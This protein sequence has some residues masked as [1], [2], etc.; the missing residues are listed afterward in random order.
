MIEIL[1]RRNSAVSYYDPLIPYLKIGHISLR[2]I[3]LSPKS[4]KKFD[5]VVI[6]TDHSKVDYKFI[7]KNSRLILDTRNVYKDINDRKI[8][9]L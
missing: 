7:L 8:S 6:A 1:Q 5:C 9:R 3:D 4:L 2:S